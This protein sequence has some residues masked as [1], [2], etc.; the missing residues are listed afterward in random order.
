MINHITKGISVTV[1]TKYN[2][3]YS[4]NEK[5]KFIFEYTVTIENQTNEPVQ[6]LRRQWFI[7]DSLAGYNEVEGEGVIGEQPII[8]PGDAYTYSS[9]CELSTDYGRMKGKYLMERKS[10]G[11]RF[12]AEIPEFELAT[13]FKLN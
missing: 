10:D 11:F 4:D 12:Y 5:G 1:V 13:N 8:Y 9:F 7:F 2:Q 3:E 6:L